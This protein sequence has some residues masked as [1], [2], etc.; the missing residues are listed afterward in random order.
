MKKLFTGWAQRC[1][2]L[3]ACSGFRRNRCCSL[4]NNT[5]L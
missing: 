5:W 2:R 1:F 3:T 4:C